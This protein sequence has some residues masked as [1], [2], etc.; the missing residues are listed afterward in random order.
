MFKHASAALLLLAAIALPACV[1]DDF[2]RTSDRS[3]IDTDCAVDADCPAGYECEV[4]EEHGE[5]WSFC[6]PHGGDDGADGGVDDDG[7]TGG[8]GGD[9]GLTCTSDADCPAGEECEIEEEHGETW[10][11]CQPHSS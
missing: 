6:K 7:G 3:T 5:T 8:T 10:S 1:V 4:E 11:F 9:D 2:G